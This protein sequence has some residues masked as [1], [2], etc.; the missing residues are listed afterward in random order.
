VTGERI[1]PRGPVRTLGEIRA[2]SAISPHPGDCHDR[3]ALTA[4]ITTS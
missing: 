1:K 4:I 2:Y 3:F